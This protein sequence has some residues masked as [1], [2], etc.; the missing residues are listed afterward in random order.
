[1]QEGMERIIHEIARCIQ[2]LQ[3]FG[4]LIQLLVELLLAL[5]RTH[6][7]LDR[8]DIR[9]KNPIHITSVWTLGPLGFLDL[10]ELLLAS[11]EL[12]D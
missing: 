5:R 3:I 9:P 2:A 1:M 8:F 4:H 6:D 10:V 12:G 11:V 7:R